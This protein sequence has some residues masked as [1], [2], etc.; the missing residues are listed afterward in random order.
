MT[1]H[2]DLVAA[3]AARSLVHVTSACDGES[4]LVDNKCSHW[5]SQINRSVIYVY[6]LSV[7]DETFKCVSLNVSYR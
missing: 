5:F 4:A 6:F 2:D 3:V 1:K 7:D